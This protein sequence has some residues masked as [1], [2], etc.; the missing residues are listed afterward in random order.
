MKTKLFSLGCVVLSV[1]VVAGAF[2][3]LYN[4][5]SI[6]PKRSSST[7][8]GSSA[9]PP[10]SSLGDYVLSF[11]LQFREADWA[12][13][14]GD[15]PTPV[16]FTVAP[17]E[18]PADVAAHLISQ[19]LIKDSDLFV[20]LVKYRHVGSNIQAGDYVLTRTM[21]MNDIVDALQHGRNRTVSII[22]RPG[23]RSEQVAAYIQTLG[24]VNFNQDLFLQTIK[25][26]QYDYGFL[27]DRPK[28][29]LP[30]MEGFLFPDTYNVPIDATNDAIFTLILGTFDER[31]TDKLR[32]EASAA[33]LTLYDVITL[34]SIVEREAVVPSERPTIAS[35]YLNRLKKKM[36]LEADPT[37][38]YSL[39]FQPA[40]GQWWK[41]GLTLDQYH[42][43]N[44]PYNTYLHPGLPPGPICNP[45][46]ASIQAVV[47][48]DR[49]DYYYFLAKGDGSHVFA[50]TY[51]EHQQNMI[52][53]GYTK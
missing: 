50:K 51:E 13:P 39:G 32:Q 27:R 3:F 15:D 49:T 35:V 33:N 36:Y 40:T 2:A 52:K 10:P 38:Q 24:L 21:T 29:A 42:Q 23:W 16:M 20:Q 9:L 18:L 28:G 45:S 11:Y 37:V 14:A 7:A 4:A 8:S 25:N 1:L 17:G 43:I 41:S 53:Y 46:L 30:T 6:L 34:A 5:L 26:G 22:I 47:E 48:P 12:S 31:V 19:G 44:S